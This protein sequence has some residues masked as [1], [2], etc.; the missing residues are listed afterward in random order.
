[1]SLQQTTS[2]DELHQKMKNF[3]A[4]RERNGDPDFIL[5]RVDDDIHELEQALGTVEHMLFVYGA[6]DLDVGKVDLD[7]DE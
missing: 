3:R 2:L 4:L 6:L 1:M 7:D 5:M